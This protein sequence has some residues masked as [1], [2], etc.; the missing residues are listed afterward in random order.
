MQQSKV[1][2]T[3]EGKPEPTEKKEF[4]LFIE[5]QKQMTSN[6]MKNKLLLKCLT[7]C[8]YKRVQD[9]SSNQF[10]KQQQKQLWLRPTDLKQS[11]REID[12][13]QVQQVIDSKQ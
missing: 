8:A 13:S 4:E 11:M 10:S 7:R 1:L 9:R 5:A 3:G 2:S 6:K 12:I